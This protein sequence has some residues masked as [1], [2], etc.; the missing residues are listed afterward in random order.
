MHTN[1]RNPWLFSVLLLILSYYIECFSTAGDTLSAAESLSV[2]ESLV[3]Q[4]S[5]FELGFFKPGTSSNI[6]LGIWYKKFDV[7]VKDI[8]IVWVA[9]RENPLTDP[10]SSRLEL[11]EDGNLVLLDRSS[12][13]PYWS[14]N[15]AF[16]MSNSTEAIIGGDGNF[17]LRDRYNLSTIFWE[18]FDHPTDTLLPGGKLRIDK[19]TGKSKQLI[20]WKNSEDPAPGMFSFGLDPNGGSQYVLEWNRSQSYWSSGIWNGRFFNLA[21]E[22][23]QNSIFNYTFVSNENESYFTYSLNNSTF[24]PSRFVINI[25]GMIQQQ[26]WLAG[27]CNWNIS[28]FQPRQKFNVYAL[29]GAFGMSYENVLNPCQ[30]L[31]GFEPFSVKDTKLYDW[32]GGCVRKSSL[33]CEDSMNTN[34]ERDW[35][36][37]KSNVRLPVNSKVNL[38][39]SATTCELV[40]MKNCSCAAYAYNSSSG[41]MIWEGPLLNLQQ[42]SDGGEAGQD[43][44]LRLSASEHRSTS[45]RGTERQDEC[46]DIYTNSCYL[47]FCKN[48]SF[49]VMVELTLVLFIIIRQQ[50]ESMGHCKRAAPCNSAS[51]M[52]LHLVFKQGKGQTQR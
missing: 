16:P 2:S 31:R 37:K 32:S 15:L 33:Q 5:I 45:L 27:H 11:S 13:K 25:S 48:T 29:C 28:W 1:T 46:N 42:L 35:F 21:P 19:I 23:K 18:S 22:M 38:T 30:C 50:M 26:M 44:Y 47:V 34:G 40:C 8:S 39:G 24:I 7:M 4:G 3:S 17:V 14:T 36:L 41:C 52:A 12:K 49:L 20:S 9:N 51:V 10:S 6:Y 43:I